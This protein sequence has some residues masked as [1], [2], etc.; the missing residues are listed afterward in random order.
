MIRTCWCGGSPS[1]PLGDAYA[2]CD[3]CGSV[4]YTDQYDVDDYTSTSRET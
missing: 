2:L 3:V 1:A 4:I